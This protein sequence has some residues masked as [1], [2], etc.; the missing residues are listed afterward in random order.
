MF[1]GLLVLFARGRFPVWPVLEGGWKNTQRD[2]LEVFSLDPTFRAS[3]LHFPPPL[4]LFPLIQSVYREVILSYVRVWKIFQAVTLQQ[5][6]EAARWLI[7]SVN[8]TAS[9]V[10]EI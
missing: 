10:S 7:F 8:Q 4:P 3:S 2:R 6:Q 5:D 1:L 9:A